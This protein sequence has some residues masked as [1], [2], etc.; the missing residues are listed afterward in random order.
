MPAEPVNQGPKTPLHSCVHD[1]P[2]KAIPCFDGGQ[3]SFEEDS[4]KGYGKLNGPTDVHNVH[5]GVIGRERPQEV[6]A[7]VHGNGRVYGNS[8]GHVD[9]APDLV[10]TGR[11]PVGADN[12]A[13]RDIALGGKGPIVPW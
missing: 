8:G 5:S 2:S 9:S 4:E 12:G 13:T 1:G 6:D 3:V 7:R 10:E 11:L